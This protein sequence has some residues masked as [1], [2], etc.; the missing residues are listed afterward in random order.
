ME[1]Q[2]RIQEEDKGRVTQEVCSIETETHL[3]ECRWFRI[4]KGGLISYFAYLN[5]QELRFTSF[6]D[7]YRLPRF[8]LQI[9]QFRSGKKEIERH[10]SCEEA[11]ANGRFKF[12]QWDREALH[13]NFGM[14][15][16]DIAKKWFHCQMAPTYC[17][18]R[19]EKLRPPSAQE[20][21]FQSSRQYWWLSWDWKFA[22]V[23]A[24]GEKALLIRYDEPKHL[25]L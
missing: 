16:E 18:V 24:N 14:Y 7:P 3:M 23:T 15:M 5:V 10:K 17:F 20:P 9:E 4:R 13:V 22:V 11:T 12:N 25:V 2:S 19:E 6:T 1:G 21:W 8:K